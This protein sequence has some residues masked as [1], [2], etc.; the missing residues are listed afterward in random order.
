VS[1]DTRILSTL[2]SSRAQFV[3]ARSKLVA[4]QVSNIPDGNVVK[5]M[6]P[7]QALVNKKLA[8]KSKIGNE[9]KLSHPDQA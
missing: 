4:V 8:L 7:D 5:L 9:V 2:V 6:Q 1:R 3:Q